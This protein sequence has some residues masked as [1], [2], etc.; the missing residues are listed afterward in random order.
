M[1]T[2]RIIMAPLVK[3]NKRLPMLKNVI[4]RSRNWGKRA[5]KVMANQITDHM[6]RSCAVSLFFKYLE[7]VLYKEK[8]DMH[9]IKSA[10]NLRFMIDFSLDRVP[11]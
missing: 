8:S 1:M 10:P 4:I 11:Y 9:T 7:N 5:K 6:T 2:K 3:K